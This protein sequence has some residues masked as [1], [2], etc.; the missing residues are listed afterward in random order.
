MG[1]AGIVCFLTQGVVPRGMPEGNFSQPSQFVRG[2]QEV[3][4]GSRPGTSLPRF[5][6]VAPECMLSRSINHHMSFIMILLDWNV[7]V[8]IFFNFFS[9]LHTPTS[10]SHHFLLTHPS[11][12]PM[13]R[14]WIGYSL[15]LQ[16]LSR[17]LCVAKPFSLCTM[18]V[19]S[20]SEALFLPST[21][22]LSFSP[23]LR[24]LYVFP[25]SFCN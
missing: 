3:S 14:V 19:P 23:L 7:C 4:Q 10:H 2:W 6:I 20:V 1:A 22:P 11:L 5:I 8:L 25:I 9:S 18:R 16:V 13:S 17:Y 12:F 24:Y 15:T 21:V